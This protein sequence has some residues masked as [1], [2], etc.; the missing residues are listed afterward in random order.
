MVGRI[1]DVGVGMVVVVDVGLG[2]G[3]RYCCSC[4]IV[5]GCFCSPHCKSWRMG[6][7]V[8]RIEMH[9]IVQ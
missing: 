7:F 8:C 2:E 4:R 9:Y 6:Y 1:V 5:E 3:S